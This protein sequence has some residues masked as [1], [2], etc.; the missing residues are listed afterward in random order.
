VGGD[1]DTAPAQLAPAASPADDGGA[2][3]RLLCG[4]L[5]GGPGTADGLVPRADDVSSSAGT[6]GGADAASPRP[7]LPPGFLEHPALVLLRP[8]AAQPGARVGDGGAGLDTDALQPAD[9]LALACRARLPRCQAT[10]AAV[11]IAAD[12]ADA[13]RMAAA[14]AERSPHVARAVYHSARDALQL[15]AASLVEWRLRGAA[16]GGGNPAGPLPPPRLAALLHNDCLVLAHAAASLTTRYVTLCLPPLAPARD[17]APP[18]PPCRAQP[19]S[20]ADLLPSLRA[21]AAVALVRQVAA[22]RDALLDVPPLDDDRVLDAME[23]GGG[24]DEGGG[25]DDGAGGHSSGDDSAGEALRRVE[26]R[27]RSQAR[28]LAAL[29]AA[30]GDVLPRV[31]FLR[32]IAH[33]VGT[34]L[35]ASA[36]AVLGLPHVSERASAALAQLMRAQASGLP[37]ALGAWCVP[38][39]EGDAAGDAAHTRQPNLV[40]LLPHWRSHAAVAELLLLPLAEIRRRAEA[41]GYVGVLPR[42]QLARLVEALFQPSAQRAAVV[43]LVVRGG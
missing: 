4:M 33:L 38:L 31:T 37:A 27:Y 19:C 18:P 10:R 36:A 34:C 30:W 39:A 6:D 29:A 41:G 42:R 8:A 20:F 9:F 13:M 16:G 22:V 21:S 25:G 3:G 1:E 7:D 5:G 43:Q 14:V 11:T 15:F 26:A 32:S 28:T 12:A 24:D 2:L 23:E 17:G 40:S 35:H